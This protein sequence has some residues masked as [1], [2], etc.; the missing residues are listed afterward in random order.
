MF[1]AAIDDRTMYGGNTTSFNAPK[2]GHSQPHGKRPHTEIIEQPASKAIR[3][4]YMCE[5]RSAGS[6]LGASSTAHTKTFP[7]IKV[8]GFQGDATVVVSCVSDDSAMRPHPHKLVGKQCKDGVV[9]AD[10]KSSDM[11]FVFDNLGIQCVRKVDIEESLRMRQELK[12]DPFRTGYS[13]MNDPKSINLS[14]VRLCFQVIVTMFDKKEN[15]SRK[16]ALEP[17]VSKP[18]LDKKSNIELTILDISDVTSKAEGGKKIMMFCDKVRV[19]DIA[20]RFFERDSEENDAWENII[21]LGVKSVH[22]QYGI[23]FHTPP[24]KDRKIEAPVSVFVQLLRP[25]DQATSEPMPFE[26][27][28]TEESVTM[29]R[30]RQKLTKS[31]SEEM[32]RMLNFPDEQIPNSDVNN[33]IQPTV[34]SQR[35]QPYHLPATFY[36]QQMHYVNYNGARNLNYVPAPFKQQPMMMEMQSTA[37]GDSRM[38]NS[39]NIPPQFIMNQNMIG[40]GL[41]DPP[42]GSTTSSRANLMH[43][44]EPVLPQPQMSSQLISNIPVNNFSIVGATNPIERKSSMNTSELCADLIA[45][46]GRK[47]G[48]ATNLD[49]N[50]D[51]LL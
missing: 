16:V 36:P 39:A 5:G 34:S 45:I 12:I 40:N 11:S 18:I 9:W 30:K 41:M 31:D 43:F 28:P 47:D 46:E 21:T 37:G 49:E 2:S 27:L 29:K 33:G 6:I 23:V 15:R 48:L 38:G 3:F 44:A 7:S 8:F 32:Y 20:V 35:A 19:H 13:H 10:I 51:N 42:R 24:Y 25:S 4:R 50:F 22:R 17:V 1:F 26:Y 14:A